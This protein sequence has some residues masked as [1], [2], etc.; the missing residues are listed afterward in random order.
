MYSLGFCYDSEPDGNSLQVEDLETIQLEGYS[1]T[2]EVVV[3]EP[4]PQ[5]PCSDKVSKRNVKP[6]KMQLIFFFFRILTSSPGAVR[7]KSV[8]HCCWW[9]APFTNCPVDCPAPLT[10][11]HVPPAYCPAHC[12]GAF[13]GPTV[14]CHS[15]CLL[16]LA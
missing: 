2:A 3:F 4:E 15:N 11:R 12:I 7:S 13:H 16:T 6:Q 14:L 5:P 8:H 9:L 1:D 10:N